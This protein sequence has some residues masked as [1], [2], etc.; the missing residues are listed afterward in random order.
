MN[1]DEMRVVAM[2]LALILIPSC[3]KNDP[4]LAKEVGMT[5]T[6]V[7]DIESRICRH[8]GNDCFLPVM[9]LNV[10]GESPI[11]T[12]PVSM[13]PGASKYVPCG[14]CHGP[15]GAGGVGPALRD[16]DVEYITDRLV[17]Y[18]SGGRVGGQS[19]LMWANAAGLSDEDI[20]QLANYIS[21]F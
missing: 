12:D 6:Q 3:G 21:N 2:I 1:M 20:N 8:D 16:R 10:E 11:I 4:G 18:R 9:A 15:T 19:N 17:T 5:K 14:A 13:D 7:A